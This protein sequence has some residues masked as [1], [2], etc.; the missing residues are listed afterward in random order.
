LGPFPSLACQVQWH[1]N[2]LLSCIHNQCLPPTPSVCSSCSWCNILDLWLTGMIP[3]VIELA[4]TAATKE[5]REQ[6]SL[7]WL[8]QQSEKCLVTHILLD[9]QHMAVHDQAKKK[10]RQIGPHLNQAILHALENR[11]VY[12]KV[13]F[14]IT[15]DLCC[16][17]TTRILPSS[18][19]DS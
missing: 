17:G 12:Y 4:L 9:I 18:M 8:H 10:K 16:L 2:F 3:L 14:H 15:T 19:W 13:A 5:D 7:T 11:V 6:F 1:C